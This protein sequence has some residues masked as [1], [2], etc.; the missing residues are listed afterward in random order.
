MLCV[1]KHHKFPFIVT[2]DVTGHHRGP[3]P[4]FRA[5]YRAPSL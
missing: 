5:C 3:K 2:S 1:N 4:K